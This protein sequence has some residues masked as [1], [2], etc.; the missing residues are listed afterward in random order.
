MRKTIC[1]LLAFVF[2]IA[3]MGAGFWFTRQ[4]IESKE[5]QDSFPLV[6]FSFLASMTKD[7][8]KLVPPYCP[9]RICPTSSST[10]SRLTC[11]SS[12]R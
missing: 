11:R 4:F 3:A 5:K 10:F 7:A 12:S 9:A 2:L 8:F 6:C 1:T